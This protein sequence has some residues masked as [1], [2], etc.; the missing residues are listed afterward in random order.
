MTTVAELLPG[1]I[2][3]GPAGNPVEAATFVAQTEHPIWPQLR[4]VVWKLHRDDSWSH[5]ALD[6][7]QDVGQAR[8]STAIGRLYNL[9]RALLHPS[10]WGPAPR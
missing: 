8:P 1:Q 9:R 6:P 4:L 7:Q 2:V 10:S 3:D 5:D